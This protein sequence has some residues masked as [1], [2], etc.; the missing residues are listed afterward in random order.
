MTLPGSR[1][2][3][4]FSVLGLTRAQLIGHARLQRPQLDEPRRRLLGEQPAGRAERRQRLVV[5]GVRA[6]ARDD[7]SRSL[8]ELDADR[9]GD[10]LVDAVHERVEIAAQRLP[11]QPGVDEVGPLALERGLELILV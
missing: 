5:D 4:A 9:P 7:A 6:R 10:L 8:E 11:P 1:P 3:D 2:G